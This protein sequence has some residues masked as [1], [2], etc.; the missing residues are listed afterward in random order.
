[1]SGADP[2][3]RC[4]VEVTLSVIGG[5]WKPII[6]YHLYAG[7]P[8]RFTTLSRKLPQVSD[9]ILARTLRELQDDRIVRR[10]VDAAM[11]VRVEYS[12]TEE[13]LSLVPVLQAMSAW[14]CGRSQ[15]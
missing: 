3:R 9:R 4:A 12:L 13:G 8:H 1:M 10:T 6:I 15:G 7:G 14:G 2:G 5:K 11:P